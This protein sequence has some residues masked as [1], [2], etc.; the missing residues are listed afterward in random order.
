MVSRARRV[1]PKA[2]NAHHIKGAQGMARGEGPSIGE[3]ANVEAS[4]VERQQ[5][6]C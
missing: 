3:H 5:S 6:Q 2:T 4:Q 1:S